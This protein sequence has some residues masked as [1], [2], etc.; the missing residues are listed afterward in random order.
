M[1]TLLGVLGL[2][3]VL[4]GFYILGK[5][6]EDMEKYPKMHGLCPRCRSRYIKRRIDG[7]WFCRECGDE[8]VIGEK[9]EPK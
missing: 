7:S 2:I 8:W 3:G 4:W 6:M 9:G 5:L 1:N